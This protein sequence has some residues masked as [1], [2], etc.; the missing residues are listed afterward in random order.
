VTTTGVGFAGVHHDDKAKAD[1]A[2]WHAA[3]LGPKERQTFT[4][5]LSRAGTT[6]DNVRGSITWAKPLSGQAADSAPIAPA[7]VPKPTQ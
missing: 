5:T 6:A 2:E 1:V 3:K 4:I 7:P